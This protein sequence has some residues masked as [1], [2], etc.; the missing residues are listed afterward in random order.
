MFLS[1][2]VCMCTI[3][4]V[5]P[6]FLW[7]KRGGGDML[8]GLKSLAFLC[9]C[10]CFWEEEWIAALVKCRHAFTLIAFY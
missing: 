9:P 2:F 5:F 3:V 7:G 1:V 8:Y 10:V 4:V 6:N